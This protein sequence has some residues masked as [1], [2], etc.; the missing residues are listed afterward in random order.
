MKKDVEYIVT[1]SKTNS[2]ILKEPNFIPENSLIEPDLSRVKG[3]PSHF[4]KIKDGHVIPMTRPEKL[5]RLE[6]I[7]KHGLDTVGCIKP[8]II[9]QLDKKSMS[10]G[11]LITG[12][13]LVVVFII[14]K[15][16]NLL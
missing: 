4:W 6:E 7:N 8:P 1:F 9:P 12:I 13:T 11:A 3:V 16:N 5:K 14:C 2:F 15:F 10:I